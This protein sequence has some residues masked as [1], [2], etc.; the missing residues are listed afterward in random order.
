MSARPL[1]RPKKAEKES[2]RRRRYAIEPTRLSGRFSHSEAA[3]MGSILSALRTWK[4]RRQKAVCSRWKG[5]G[6]PRWGSLCHF[7]DLA[8]KMWTATP[9]SG[10][11]RP[12]AGR[13]TLV[14]VGCPLPTAYCLLPTASCLLPFAY[15]LL[16]T[17]SCLLP[18]AY[19]LLPTADCRLPTAGCFSPSFMPNF[20]VSVWLFSGHVPTRRSPPPAA[21]K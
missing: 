18:F 9:A 19:R 15:C 14:F 7:C 4:R 11:P 20:F 21:E 12:P 13:P 10:A 17:A 8:A 6:P 16:P 5:T 3:R 1:C 2:Q